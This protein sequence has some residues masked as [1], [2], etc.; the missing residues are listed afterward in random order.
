MTEPP[1]APPE[2]PGVMPAPVAHARALRRVALALVVLQAGLIVVGL[3]FRAVVYP[4]LGVA[5]GE[6]YGLGDVLELFIGAALALASLTAFV[7]ALVLSVV[8]SL[9]DGRALAALLLSGLGAWPLS[10]A[11][12]ALL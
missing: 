4:R 6:P 8:R 5:P 7:A 3:A 11:L 1:Y 12:R 9:R 10:L 2:A